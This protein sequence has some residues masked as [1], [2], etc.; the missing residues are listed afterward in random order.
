MQYR[1]EQVGVLTS[2]SFS[3]YFACASSVEVPSTLFHASLR[4][5]REATVSIRRPRSAL[6][7]WA[8]RDGATG[9]DSP[10]CL[11]NKVEH[12]GARR[13]DVA[14]GGCGGAASGSWH[15]S[16]VHQMIESTPAAS[17]NPA[18]STCRTARSE[19][20]RVGESGGNGALVTRSEAARRSSEKGRT[21][22]CSSWEG[23]MGP[24][25]GRLWTMATAL[26]N[27]ALDIVVGEQDEWQITI[28]RRPSPSLESRTD[29]A[30]GT[31]RRH[32]P[33]SRPL[34][35]HRRR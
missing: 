16:A 32:S 33:Q 11:A 14:N 24:S 23:W 9:H 15:K 28:S 6:T 18:C 4:V 34:H 17:T 35:L 5:I 12:A 20:G 30:C 26:S 13:V 27:F 7:R 19:G 25:L 22:S 8:A 21:K 1:R 3:T 2:R 31:P 10:L 29:R